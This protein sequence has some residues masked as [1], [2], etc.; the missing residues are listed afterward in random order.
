M[1]RKLWES[2]GTAQPQLVDEDTWIHRELSELALKAEG[3]VLGWLER[4]PRSEQGNS[5]SKGV[6]TAHL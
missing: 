4:I 5:H 2:S 3:E 6:G 1:H